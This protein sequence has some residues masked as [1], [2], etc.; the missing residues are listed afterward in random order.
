MSGTAFVAYVKL[1]PENW[2]CSLAIGTAHPPL[3]R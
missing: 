2:R 1:L 3:S